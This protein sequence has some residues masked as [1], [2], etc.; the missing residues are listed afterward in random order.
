[1]PQ[2]PQWEPAFSVGHELIDN[3]HQDLLALCNRLADH[4]AAE[5]GDARDQAFDQDFD[6]LKA[7]AQQHFEAE[8]AWLTQH[9]YPALEEH[10]FAFDELDDLLQDIVTTEHFDREELQRF[11][12]LWWLGHI[13][14]TAP[15][16]RAFAA[17]VD[18]PR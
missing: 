10:L 12:S 7:L 8:S 17:G 11:L 2:R 6:R 14:G 18:P 5:A 9:G 1:M 16:L 13:A 15:Q 3:Q 4:C